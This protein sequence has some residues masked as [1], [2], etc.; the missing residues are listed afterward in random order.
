MCTPVLG[1]FLKDAAVLIFFFTSRGFE[2]IIRSMQTIIR[3]AQ[4]VLLAFILVALAPATTLPGDQCVAAVTGDTEGGQY[5]V[6]S[7][8]KVHRSGCRYYGK[9]KGHMESNPSGPNC[10]ICGGKR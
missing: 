1:N 5:W 9:G 6:S 4:S 3:Y 10:K 7:T 2:S 8:G